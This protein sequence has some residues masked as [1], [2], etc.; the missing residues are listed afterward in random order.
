MN[1]QMKARSR[2]SVSAC[3][4]VSVWAFPQGIKKPAVDQEALISFN[5]IPLSAPSFLSEPE[6]FWVKRMDLERDLDSLGKSFGTEANS[7]YRALRKKP[8]PISVAPAVRSPYSRVTP[9]FKFQIL[10]AIDN[11]FREVGPVFSIGDK[12]YF[13]LTNA[14]I[15]DGGK[16][17]A[18]DVL[19]RINPMNWYDVVKAVKNSFFVP[20]RNAVYEFHRKQPLELT[21]SSRNLLRT[22]R[23]KLAQL[24]LRQRLYKLDE[25][26]LLFSCF[27]LVPE[28]NAFEVIDLT[29][30]Q[31]SEFFRYLPWDFKHYEK[32]PYIAQVTAATD[33]KGRIY[34]AFEFSAN[35]YRVWILDS[36]GGILKTL[37]AFF[38]DPEEYDFPWEWLNLNFRE[39]TRF[40]I[41]PIYAIE[42]LLLFPDGRLLVYFTARS[43]TGSMTGNYDPGSFRKKG[44]VDM[45]QADGRYLG[46]GEFPFGTPELIDG[47]GRIY[48]RVQ[49]GE[50]IRKINVV[51]L[52]SENKIPAARKR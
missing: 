48:S 10:F 12:A 9:S 1:I 4:L 46:R 35:P 40:A 30:K 26:H 39:I 19:C 33:G 44:Y 36:R 34:A 41:R 16:K 13:I 31:K 21:V 42:R 20:V 50:N 52:N 51:A 38:T 32:T 43:K 27:R 22:G 7:W 23:M 17:K 24:R 29:G 2:I 14:A 45:F 18:A 47:Q 28:D 6:Y 8:M 15:E 37:S 11:A 25:N 5:N 3:L 49:S